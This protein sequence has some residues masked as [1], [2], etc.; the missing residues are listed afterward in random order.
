VKQG[1]YN[2]W[3]VLI[4]Q[5][6][7][8][9]GKDKGD[10]FLACDPVQAGPGDVV[11]AAREGNAARQILGKEEDPFHAVI[12]GIVDFVEVNKRL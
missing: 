6:I 5:P 12:T 3:K 7:D 1:C 11:I 10:S 8:A 9:N 2:G 4:L